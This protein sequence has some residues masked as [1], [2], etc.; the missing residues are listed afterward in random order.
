MVGGA[1]AHPAATPEP[2]VRGF[3]SRG[4]SAYG[5]SSQA[6]TIPI[7]RSKYNQLPTSESHEQKGGGEPQGL[8]LFLVTRGRPPW[9]RCA[10]PLET[11]RAAPGRCSPRVGRASQS[12]PR[13]C[14][15]NRGLT[16]GWYWNTLDDMHITWCFPR[17]SVYNHPFSLLMWKV[18]VEV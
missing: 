11:H 3:P 10:P 8:S 5:S 16:I 2:R 6:P 4:S 18:S 9:P 15:E 7:A 14:T 17:I 12:L 13:S 1:V